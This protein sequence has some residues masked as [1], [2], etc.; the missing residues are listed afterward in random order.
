[1]TPTRTAVAT[2]LHARTRYV[3]AGTDPLHTLGPDGAAWWHDGAGFATAGTAA[4]VD[5]DEVR[6]AGAFHE[7]VLSSTLDEGSCPP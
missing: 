1:M 5:V 3:D 4:R 6:A 7:A 2:T